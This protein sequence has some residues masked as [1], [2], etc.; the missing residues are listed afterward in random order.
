MQGGAQ[1]E[2]NTLNSMLSIPRDRSTIL[3]L[4]GPWV[5]FDLTL[6]FLLWHGVLVRDVERGYVPSQLVGSLD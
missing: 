2:I 4:P 3:L 1:G 6:G 5:V